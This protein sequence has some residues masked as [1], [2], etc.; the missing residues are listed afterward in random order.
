[1]KW[2]IPSFSFAV[3]KLVFGEGA[4]RIV[5]KVRF[6]DHEKKFVG[7]KMVAKESR[8]IQEGQGTY[9]DRM[10]YHRDFLRTQAIASELAD[11]FNAAL[12]SM[13]MHFPHVPHSLLD[14]IP[15]IR[16]LLSLIHI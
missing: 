10:N 11:Q 3:K 5:Y 12:A 6:L 1:M 16:F 4:E 13:K 14:D 2:A 15:R 8:F 7:P 9:E